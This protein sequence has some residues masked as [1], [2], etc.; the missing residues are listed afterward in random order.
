MKKIAGKTN[1]Q[2]WSKLEKE[3][4]KPLIYAF[5]GVIVVSIAGVLV[6]RAYLTAQSDTLVNPF[7]GMTYTNINIDD[8]L[9]A[10]VTWTIP[11]GGSADFTV[12]KHAKV[13]VPA[14][15]ELKPVYVRLMITTAVYESVDKNGVLADDISATLNPAV[16]ASWTLNTTDWTKKT[17]NGVD[18]YYYNKIVLPTDDLN[19]ITSDIFGTGNNNVTVVNGKNIPA[20]AEVRINVIAD[21]VQAVSVDT[22]N[23]AKN[24]SDKF[25]ATEVAQA[26]GLTPTGPSGGALPGVQS[27]GNGLKI[28]WPA[29]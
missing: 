1:Q 5:F 9:S 4:M 8:T 18:Y 25:S 6:V 19:G 27:T 7:S 13:D 16:Y 20:G 15:N 10:D 11:E 28:E 3:R 12:T 17:V 29:T 24:S 2:K 21:T 14:S 23:W 22:V 26:W